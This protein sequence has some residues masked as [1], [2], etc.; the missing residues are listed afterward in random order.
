MSNYGFIVLRHVNSI[1]TNLYWNRSCRLLKKFYPDCKIVIIDDNSNYNFIKDLN[2]LDNIEVI[3][4]EYHARGELLPFIYYLKY[5]WFDNAVIIHDSTFFHKRINFDKVNHPILPIWNFTYD[6]ENLPN[7]LRIAYQ[8]RNPAKIVECLTNNHNVLNI[9]KSN[10]FV[11]CFGVQCF[12]NYK[13]LETINNSYQIT[14]LIP[15]ILNRSDRCALERVMGVLFTMVYPRL[16]DYKSLL[17]DIHRTGTWGTT[18]DKYIIQ[19]KSGKPCPYI[20]KV[21]TGR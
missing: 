12:I 18:F 5:K 4:S 15:A 6:R 9:Y 16:V 2:N 7:L 14:N 17:G 3:Q 11:C 10:E 19:I 1:K 20:S 8:L 13:L 21:W